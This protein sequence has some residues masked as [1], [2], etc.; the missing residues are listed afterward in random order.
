M[1]EQIPIF[2]QAA[3]PEF[4][5][6]E[7]L[8]LLAFI[9]WAVW[10]TLSVVDRTSRKIDRFFGRS[11]TSH[12]KYREKR[13]HEANAFYYSQEWNELRKAV[14]RTYGCVCMKCGASNTVMQVDHIKPRSK[15][16][17]LAWN[18]DNLQVLCK[19]CNQRKGNKHSTDYRKARKARISESRPRFR[20]KFGLPSKR[21]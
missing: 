12:R 4:E 20:D 5:G 3:T 16:P 19:E 7:F 6:N 15:Y 17:E 8:I 10:Q 11:S 9:G 2:I 1:F 21:R 13:K 14:L 18:F